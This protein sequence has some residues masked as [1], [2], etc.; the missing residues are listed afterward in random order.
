[1]ESIYVK[2]PERMAIELLE[3][4]LIENEQLRLELFDLKAKLQK[5]WTT[6]SIVDRLTN[7]LEAAIRDKEEFAKHAQDAADDVAQLEELNQKLEK[8]VEVL[9]KDVHL[10]KS[11]CEDLETEAEEFRTQRDI[12]RREVIAWLATNTKAPQVEQIVNE[13]NWDYLRGSTQ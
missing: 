7:D 9:T 12:A 11:S 4:K 1:M 6:E 5:P 10:Y 3:A 13:R 8:Q 2:M